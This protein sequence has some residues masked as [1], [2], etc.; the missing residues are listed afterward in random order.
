MSVK[1][2]ISYKKIREKIP[3]LTWSIN[4]RLICRLIIRRIRVPR[5]I[6]QEVICS[7]ITVI[8]SCLVLRISFY[9]SSHAP[10]IKNT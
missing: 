3:C 2:L 1:K 8:L 7:L 6:E 4:G 10:F 9:A 5:F